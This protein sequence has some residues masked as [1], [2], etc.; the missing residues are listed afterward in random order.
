MG[1]A[2]WPALFL[3]GIAVALCL[4]TRDVVIESAGDSALAVLEDALAAKVSYVGR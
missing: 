1:L 4:L 3:W 2:S